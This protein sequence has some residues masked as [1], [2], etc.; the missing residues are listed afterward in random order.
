LLQTQLF[1]LNTWLLLAVE[2]DTQVMDLVAVG[3][4]ATELELLQAV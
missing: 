1:L 4:V 2:R 3:L